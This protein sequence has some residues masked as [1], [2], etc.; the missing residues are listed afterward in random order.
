MNVKAELNFLRISPRKVRLV[1]SLIQ[2]MPVSDAFRQLSIIPKRSSMPIEKL[3]KSA[4]ANAEHNFNLKADTLFVKEAIVN[5]GPVF[6]RFMPRAR[7]SAAMIRKRTSHVKIVLAEAA[8]KKAK[9]PKAK[10]VKKASA[11]TK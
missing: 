8:P 3:L 9:A 11:E 2:G 5:Q 4:V 10:A 1:T 7:G 6:K